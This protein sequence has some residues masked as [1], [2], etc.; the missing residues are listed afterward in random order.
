MM[1]RMDMN[2]YTSGASCKI[3]TATPR[4]NFSI[5][6]IQTIH[7]ENNLNEAIQKS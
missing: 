5:W 2:I 1:R 7:I 6:T 4:N 3:N